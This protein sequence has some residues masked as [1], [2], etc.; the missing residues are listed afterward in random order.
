MPERFENSEQRYLQRIESER[1]AQVELAN[2]TRLLTDDSQKISALNKFEDFSSPVEKPIEFK[3]SKYGELVMKEISF[4]ESER[5]SVKYYT[6][7]DEVCQRILSFDIN[8]I[9]SPQRFSEKAGIESAKAY[10]EHYEGCK[11]AL[12]VGGKGAYDLVGLDKNGQL[13]VGELKGHI[14]GGVKTIND[15]YFLSENKDL[16]NIAE[17]SKIWMEIAYSQTFTK[18]FYDKSYREL[19]TRLEELKE[20]SPARYYRLR[21]E[22]NRLDENIIDYKP[23]NFDK[24]RRIF[25][26]TGWDNNYKVGDLKELYRQTGGEMVIIQLPNKY[27]QYF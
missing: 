27:L 8:E 6:P 7:S 16:K 26:C 17:L 4:N 1:I 2:E 3:N 22:L 13:I 21:N 12:D 15:K 14:F 9:N 25:I 23:E 10:L 11:V 19:E 24:Y 20:I 18:E 5:M